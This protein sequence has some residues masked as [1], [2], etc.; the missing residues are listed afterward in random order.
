MKN[1]LTTIFGLTLAALFLTALLL[2]ADSAAA[3]GKTDSASGEFTLTVQPDP[4]A[5][6]KPGNGQ[7]LDFKML[8]D[9]KILWSAPKL[10]ID[11][12]G[13]GAESMRLQANLDSGKGVLLYP[14]TLNG[15]KGDIASLDQ[16]G[17]LSQFSELMQKGGEAPA[18]EGWKREASGSEKVGTA[19]CT[20]YKLTSPK[21]NVVHWWVDSEGRPRRI[22][23]LRGGMQV[24]VDISK[25][26]YSARVPDSSFDYGKEY[27][28]SE[29]MKALLSGQ[30]FISLL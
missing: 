21:G 18:P 17:Y 2:P 9:G 13:Q 15:Y 7:S 22:Q 30:A 10:R 27:T 19:K 11:L 4:A 24:R 5:A 14:D 29:V 8:F 6:K 20:K 26:D 12:S 3:K 1:T 23:T 25:L 28:I 16:F